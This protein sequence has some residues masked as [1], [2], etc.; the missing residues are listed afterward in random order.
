MQG[1]AALT[2]T[3]WA[4]TVQSWRKGNQ[5]SLRIPHVLCGFDFEPSGFF[6]EGGFDICHVDHAWC[7][8]V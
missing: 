7:C 3:T 6:G 2:L 8:V 1:I 5:D 4:R